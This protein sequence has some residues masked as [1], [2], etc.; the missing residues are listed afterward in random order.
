MILAGGL[1]PTSSCIFDRNKL[2][3]FGIS[4]Y[5]Y[6][7]F[8]P[9]V[10]A[11]ECACWQTPISTSP[12]WR[13]KLLSWSVSHQGTHNLN[14]HGPKTVSILVASIPSNRQTIFGSLVLLLCYTKRFSD[15]NYKYRPLLNIHSDDTY[16]YLFM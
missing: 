13:E 6:M 4:D 11:V 1:T 16:M 9:Q 14:Y 15:L 5:M 12:S 8:S 3:H 2:T 10:A 7:I